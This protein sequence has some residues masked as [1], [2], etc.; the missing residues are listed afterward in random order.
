MD[1]AYS[2]L[3][4]LQEQCT[5]SALLYALLCLCISWPECSTCGCTPSYLLQGIIDDLIAAA[6]S[7]VEMR[8]TQAVVDLELAEWRVN[9]PA[10]L[11]AISRQ[12]ADG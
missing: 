7:H 6:L 12:V 1:E 4:P 11:A 2:T 3:M 10:A 5:V 8:P 9:Q